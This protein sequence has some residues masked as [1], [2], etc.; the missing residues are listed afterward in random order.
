MM[1]PSHEVVSIQ[2]F[3]DRVSRRVQIVNAEL[4]ALVKEQD[5]L[6]IKIGTRYYV[7]ADIV[8]EWIENL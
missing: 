3:F 5:F 4:Q 7:M 8:N 2:D 1:D 6:A